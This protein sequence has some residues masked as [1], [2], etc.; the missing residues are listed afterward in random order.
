MNF[1]I[2]SKL[3]QIKICTYIFGSTRWLSFCENDGKQVYIISACRTPIGSF[4][5]KLAQFSAPQLGSFAIRA[6]LDKYNIP[7]EC[8]VI[9]FVDLF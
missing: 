5:S 3:C 6:N 7:K 1:L 2:K 9:K 8:N 4:R